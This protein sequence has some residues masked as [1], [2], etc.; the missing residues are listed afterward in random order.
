MDF[1]WRKEDVI[2]FEVVSFC[3]G[4]ILGRIETLHDI[5]GIII[6]ILCMGLTSAIVYV[7]VDNT[8]N[9]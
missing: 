9:I 2:L 1:F 5:V 7:S 6:I 3:N 8:H 4:F